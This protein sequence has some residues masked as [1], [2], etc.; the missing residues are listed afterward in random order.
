MRNVSL[1]TLNV[2]GN[3]ESPLVAVPGLTSLGMQP[4]PTIAYIGSVSSIC[5]CLDACVS[6]SLLT[7]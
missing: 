7:A 6:F 5:I 3:S 4:C 1:G 2:D